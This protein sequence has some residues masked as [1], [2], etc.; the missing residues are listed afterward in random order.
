M[1][2]TLHVLRVKNVVSKEQVF[3][4]CIDLPAIK[5]C[6]LV[7]IDLKVYIFAHKVGFT[8]PKVYF[9]IFHC[10]L[11]RMHKSGGYAEILMVT[12]TLRVSPGQ[13]FL[14]NAG[15]PFSCL[16]EL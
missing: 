13:C 14:S 7:E 8:G 15:F 2:H 4:V 1:R 16:T 9:F 3:V 10:L 12:R 6:I 11:D 5:T